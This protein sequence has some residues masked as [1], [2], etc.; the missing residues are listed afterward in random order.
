MNTA[1]YHQLLPTQ[2][3]SRFAVYIPVGET[4]LWQ[5]WDEF[6]VKHTRSGGS[7]DT[8]GN[9][10][11]T[12]LVILRNTVMHSLESWGRFADL[13]DELYRIKQERNWSSTTLWTYIKN[14]NTYFRFL[15]RYEH[16][17]E[18]PI[19]KFTK[20]RIENND[21]YTLTV[22][23]SKTILGHISS[24]KDT[25]IGRLRNLLFFQLLYITGARKCELL[26]LNLLDFTE[27]RSKVKIQGAKQKGKPRYYPLPQHIKDTLL[28]YIRHV[29]FLNRTGE[30]NEHLFISTSKRTGWTNKGLNKLCQRMS[31]ELGFRVICYGFRRMV[32]TKLYK[33]GLDIHGLMQHLGHTRLSTTLRYVDKQAGLTDKG[34]AIM[35]KSYM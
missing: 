24:R 6:V 15:E 18:N 16:I 31:K 29:G 14:M 12:M 5:Y 13:E 28:E 10:K 20:V 30:L 8:V 9:V 21:Q 22:G 35:E 25:R 26:S 34:V 19:K 1:S 33:E 27:G 4:P 32:S 7:L 3:L 2:E 23:Q 11:D 17:K